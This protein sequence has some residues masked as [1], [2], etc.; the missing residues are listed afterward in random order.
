[1]SRATAAF[2]LSRATAAFFLALLRGVPAPPF[3]GQD[4]D[5]ERRRPRT[6]VVDF[7]E[8]ARPWEDATPGVQPDPERLGPYPADSYRSCPEFFDITA[9]WREAGRPRGLFPPSRS[10]EDGP[11]R[12]FGDIWARRWVAKSP[13]LFGRGRSGSRPRRRRDSPATREAKGRGQCPS[14][15]RNRRRV[16]AKGT[17]RLGKGE[18]EGGNFCVTLALARGAL[19][20]PRRPRRDRDDAGRDV[21]GDDRVLAG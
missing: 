10:R 11:R 19:L 5:A 16:R 7:I 2:F 13:R 6:R 20:L 8:G 3:S 9:K 18:G 4:L 12:R 21:P 17:T 14:S 1:M 15:V